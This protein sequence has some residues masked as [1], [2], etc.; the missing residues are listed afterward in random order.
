MRQPVNVLDA[1]DAIRMEDALLDHEELRSVHKLYN[2][3]LCTKHCI[4]YTRCLKS[5][6][7]KSEAE[8]L[9]LSHH[10]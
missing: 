1:T 4:T 10:S 9:T 5:I 6:P 2:L 3:E 8:Y 7:K